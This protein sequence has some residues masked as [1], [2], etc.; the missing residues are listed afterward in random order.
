[1]VLV[2]AQ[3]WGHQPESS[4]SSLSLQTHS[5]Q[6]WFN[7]RGF[8]RAGTDCWEP[9]RRQMEQL[10]EFFSLDW[11]VSNPGIP[12]PL[13]TRP[14][15]G[16]KDVPVRRLDPW[17]GAYSSCLGLRPCWGPS[18]PSPRLR[19]GSR[20]EPE[21][22]QTSPNREGERDRYLPGV[23]LVKLQQRLRRRRVQLFNVHFSSGKLPAPL[24]RRRNRLA[25]RRPE[26]A[27]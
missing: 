14:G 19:S 8:P 23:G 20:E 18:S 15:F 21:V 4:L 11:W 17:A 1:M 22:G 10:G 25:L 2:S 9:G 24:N 3:Q 6:C 27:L 12:P 16:V 26:P 13:P 5:T 7:V